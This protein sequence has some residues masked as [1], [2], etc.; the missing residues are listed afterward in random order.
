MK[1][2]AP[3]K[4]RKPL[5]PGTKRMK[6][7][8]RAI[9]APSAEEQAQ[10]D[11]QRAKGC[12]MCHLLHAL[13]LAKR[14]PSWVRIHHRTTGDLHGNPQLGQDKTVALC[15]WHHQGVLLEGYTV[16]GM[17]LAF[18]PSL[19]HHKRAFLTVLRDHLGDWSTGALQ[20]Y[21]LEHMECP[22]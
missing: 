10:Q 17:L 6:Q 22:T 9:G 5:R 13:G 16:L 3:L 21:Q 11:A 15:D 2:S 14:C 19:H 8:H 7:R 1:R 12:A 4:R 18:G 20:L